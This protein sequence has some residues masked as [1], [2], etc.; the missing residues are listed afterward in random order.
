MKA[1]LQ[2]DSR[3]DLAVALRELAPGEM[4]DFG[5]GPVEVTE[6]IPAKQK[7]ALK[8][9]H[10]G[11]TATM[12][13][14]LVGKALRAIPQGGLIS[15]ANLAHE[16]SPFDVPGRQQV[17][18][19][20][21]PDVSAWK[22]VTF[23]GFHRSDGSVGTANYWLVVPLVFCE[24]RNIEVLRESLESVLGYRRSTS[25]ESYA[26]GLLDHWKAH[27]SFREMLEGQYQEN[28][29]IRDFLPAEDRPFPNVDGVK[30]LTH[31]MGCGGTREDARTL[32]G[33]LAGY[34]THPN[35][36]GATVLSLGC[37]NAQI[38]VLEEAIAE[39]A[40]GFDKPLHIFEQ[41]AWPSERQMLEAAMK[42]TFAG[43]ARANE[44]TRAPA[45]LSK[46]ILGVECGGSD[47]FSGISANP[48]IGQVSDF[49]VALGGSVI[50]SEFPE[51]CG[52]EQE[53]INRCVDD[54]SAARFGELMSLYHSRAEAVGAGFYQNPSPGNIRDGLITDA[55]K[56]AGAAKKGG[57]SL[58]TSVLDYPEWVTKPGLNLMC[59][60][61][62]DVESTTAM[63]GAH[64]NI[65]FF[66]TGLGTPTG[67]P[68][69]PVLKVATNTELA[70]RM[71]DIIDFDTGAIIRGEKTLLELGA[72]LFDMAIA[73]ASGKAFPK[74]QL[75]GQND[76]LPWKRGVSL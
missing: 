15:T 38:S 43:V 39:R 5:Q 8:P 25:Y 46:L 74:A 6:R 41:Q 34:I 70:S 36:A 45:P 62:G 64:A 4:L 7:V 67:N 22:E 56:S 61:G 68:I 50:L 42:Q 3:D 18:D 37:Q 2:I 26:R 9:F 48:V 49:L 44:Y 60:P 29:E 1:A 17:T 55:I 71:P 33:L 12:Y 32:C 24:N 51:L 69:C 47:G 63:A 11:D 65:M 35:V 31:G 66:S 53:L 52:V 30:F 57:T 13:G 72:D 23:D 28:L 40:P 20:S 27:G 10:V 19:W 16:A 73:V 14:V 59:T 76:F 54:A 58:V 21:A 75:L